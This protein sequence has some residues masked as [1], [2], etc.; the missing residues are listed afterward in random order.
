ME[1]EVSNSGSAGREVLAR[2]WRLQQ[3]EPRS[4]KT[5]VVAF[6]SRYRRFAVSSYC[7]V[8]R[9]ACGLDGPRAIWAVCLRP[10]HG[11]VP[12]PSLQSLV[13]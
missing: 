6:G 10:Q 8:F 4:P 1:L 2:G 12:L 3:R 5:G 11:M 7:L 9:L 13:R